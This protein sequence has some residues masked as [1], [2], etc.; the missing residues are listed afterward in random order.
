M[1][2]SARTRRI[3]KGDPQFSIKSSL[4]PEI[5]LYYI[6]ILYVP[7]ACTRRNKKEL[8]YEREI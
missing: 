5:L 3:A 1:P 4:S 8:R 2:S 6:L 7:R